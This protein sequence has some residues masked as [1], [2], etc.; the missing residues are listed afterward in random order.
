MT[1]Q[2]LLHIYGS[3]LTEFLISIILQIVVW[4]RL[5]KKHGKIPRQMAM[6]FLLFAG[7]PLLSFAF[8][9]SIDRLFLALALGGAYIMTFPAAA[10][11]S[12]TILIIDILDKNGPQGEIEI[13][14]KLRAR[15]NL[16][17]DRVADL[18]SDGLGSRDGKKLKVTFPGRA[19]GYVFWTYRR[20]LGL[21][22]GEG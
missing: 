19:I 20:L 17:E 18:E 1:P 21:P 11:E 5:W 13:S 4:R 6:L 8:D 15:V 22:I 9:H 14:E 16:S 3:V 7:L 2:W 10:A 12:P